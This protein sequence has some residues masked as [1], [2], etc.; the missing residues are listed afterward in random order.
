MID[1]MK[2]YFETE[3]TPPTRVHVG[4]RMVKSMCAMLICG[5]V[6][7][8]LNLNPLFAMIAA[9]MS[10]QRNM[11]KTVMA[12]LNRILATLIGGVFGLAVLFIGLQTGALQNGLFYYPLVALMI[13]PVI[14]LTILIRKSSLSGLAGV[15]MICVSV[16]SGTG[17][18][19]YVYAFD[20]IFQTAMGVV[21]AVLVNLALPPYGKQDGQEEDEPPPVP[22]APSDEENKS[23][24]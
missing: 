9:L 22:S 21:V 18:S 11:E 19:I 17:D 8:A 4:M 12:A 10:M 23:G 3:E 20:R 13:I 6:D 16:L 24:S 14:V 7:W 1:K 2:N 15:A 5:L